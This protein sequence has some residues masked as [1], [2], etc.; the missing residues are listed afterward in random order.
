MRPQAFDKGTVGVAF[1]MHDPQNTF[2]VC[3]NAEENSTQLYRVEDGE[4]FLLTQTYGV[5]PYQETA[6]T[7]A[8]IETHHGRLKV[9]V[10]AEGTTWNPIIE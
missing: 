7:R 3:F 8:R 10:K 5:T 9:A 2:L 4:P 6:W 1:R